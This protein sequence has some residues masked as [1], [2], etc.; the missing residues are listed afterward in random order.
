MTE[1][2]FCTIALNMIWRIGHVKC[3]KI[4]AYFGGFKGIFQKKKSDIMDCGL[5]EADADAIL[6]F[7]LKEA[8]REIKRCKEL[9]IRI[10]LKEDSE[11]PLMLA[12]I[13][14]PPSVLYMAGLPY[15]QRKNPVAV[16]GTRNATIYGKRVTEALIKEASAFGD[17]ISIISGMAKGIDSFAHIAAVSNNIYTAAVLGFGLQKIEPRDIWETSRAISRAGTLISEFPLDF[18]ASKM[19]FPRRNRIIS[20]MSRAVIV[21]EAGEK[22]GTLITVDFALEQG[23]DVF[24]VPGDIFS[25]KSKGVNRIISEGAKVLYSFEDVLKS[26]GEKPIFTRELSEKKEV[27]ANLSDS[28]KY[29][30]EKMGI[31]KKHI[32]IIA[33][34]SNMSVA[35]LSV[36]LTI[37]ELKGAVKQLEGKTFVRV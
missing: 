7:D 22:S 13:Y 35:K 30:Y 28:E 11:Y 14:D 29:V 19:S 27:H 23:R 15:I 20:G 36:L 34:E 37:M 25:K 26:F 6:S 4:K 2:R 17:E 3:E 21:V 9:D 5:K 33:I 12:D 8:E 24:A 10:V 32:D 18:K 16:I 31:E 1:E